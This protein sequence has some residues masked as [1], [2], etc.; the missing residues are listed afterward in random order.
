MVG[1]EGAAR[2]P[3]LPPRAEHEVV[4]D[5]LAAA[6]EEVGQRRLALWPLERIGLVDLHPW[7]RAPLG[8]QLI[9]QP[10]EFL[11]PCQMRLARL[12]PFVSR[13]DRVAWHHSSFS[14]SSCLVWV[15]GSASPA[16]VVPRSFFMASAASPPPRSRWR[17][18]APRSRCTQTHGRLLHPTSRPGR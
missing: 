16:P 4:Y 14:K 17:R 11:F 3:L 9:A 15:V 6:V 8:A 13:H 10:R 18:S 5:Q 2:A 12:E 1:Q 7:H